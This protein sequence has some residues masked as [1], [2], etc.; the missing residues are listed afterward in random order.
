[1][2]PLLIGGALSDDAVWRL[3][4]VCLVS[5]CLSV[6]HLSVVYIGPKSRTESPRK[7]QIGTKVV[8]V[9]R[10]S[11]TPLSSS[12]GQRSRSPGRFTHRSLNAWC[13]CSGD[14]EKVLGAGNYCYV[15]SALRLVRHL[16]GAHRGGEGRAH[17][18]SPR[19]QLVAS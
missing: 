5:D 2:L 6:W 11:D 9:I 1:M 12:K 17:I 15:A 18:V 19:A 13:R 10:D 7:I 16:I 14:C 4:G 8:H 3:S